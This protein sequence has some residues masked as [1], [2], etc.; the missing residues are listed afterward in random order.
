MDYGSSLLLLLCCW[1]CFAPGSTCQRSTV[2]IG[3]MTFCDKICLL[4]FLPGQSDIYVHVHVESSVLLLIIKF[5]CSLSIGWLKSAELAM[6]Y[7][8]YYVLQLYIFAFV[9]PPSNY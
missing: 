1:L 9:Q 3:N 6:M 5:Y 7:V 4:R 8:C 2:M